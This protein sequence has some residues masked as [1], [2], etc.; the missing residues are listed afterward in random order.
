MSWLIDIG[1]YLFE[2]IY[3][4]PDAKGRRG[5]S[6]VSKALRK[7]LPAEDYV[8]LDSLT[9]PIKGSTT[10]IDHTILSRFGIFVVE[11]K[12]KNGWIF[13]SQQKSTW[14]QAFRSQSFKFQ[15]PLRQNYRHV[16][17]IE[18]ILGLS[19]N[20]VHSVV[21]FVGSAEPKTDFPRNV[22]CPS[23]TTKLLSY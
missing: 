7:G 6:W 20:E 13:G 15:N 2:K 16:K 11:T 22:V 9:L 8:V 19:K 17:A 1:L 12:N 3:N 23:S 4:S 5:E 10:Q 14:T 21:A 18:E